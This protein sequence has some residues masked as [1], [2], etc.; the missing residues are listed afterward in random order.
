MEGINAALVIEIISKFGT[1]GVLVV[2]WWTDR[3]Q[4]RE[5]HDYNE[6]QLKSVLERYESDM[7]ELRNMYENNASLVRGY[8]SVAGDL[9]EVVIMNTQAVTQMCAEM[10]TNQY[11]PM[12]RVE[13]FVKGVQS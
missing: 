7:R 4:L 5:Q 11:C 9:K 8:E 6:K 12:V 3:K 2:V 1:L 10:K 13:K